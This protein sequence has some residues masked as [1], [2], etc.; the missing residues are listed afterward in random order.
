MSRAQSLRT[1]GA[2]R[3]HRSFLVWRNGLYAKLALL[4]AAA[5]VLL[6]WLDQ[7]VGGPSGGSWLGYAL[8]SLGFGLI[9]WLSWFGIRRRRYGKT[10]LLEEW[11]SAHVYFG[12]AL[13][14]IATLHTGFQFHGNVHLLAFVLMILVIGSGI[15]GVYAYWRYPALMTVNRSGANI[16]KIAATLASLDSRCRGLALGFD[17]PIQDLVLEALDDVGGRFGLGELLL[18]RKPDMLAGKTGA[19][20]AG[21]RQAVGGPGKLTPGESLPLVQ[22]LTERA[23]LLLQAR[24][25]R[26]YRALLL[27]WRAVHVPLTFALLVTLVVHVFAVFYYW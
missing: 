4:L 22:L 7:P 15:F 27:L 23:A 11:L 3:I 17:D 26:R 25:D 1:P 12:L 18:G 5:A 13:I 10:G 16:D 9:A 21:L 14:V 6:Y 24:R 2:D 20:L 19:A 8:G